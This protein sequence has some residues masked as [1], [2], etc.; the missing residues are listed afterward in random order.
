VDHQQRPGRDQ[1]N[2][3]IRVVLGDLVYASENVPVLRPRVLCARRAVV[4]VRLAEQASWWKRLA[5]A[6]FTDFAKIPDYFTKTR[7]S[8]PTLSIAPGGP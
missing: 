5:S 2:Q 1:V 6:V 8:A 7:A 4:V 3:V